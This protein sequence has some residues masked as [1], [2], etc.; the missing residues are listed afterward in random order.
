MLNRRPA[1][2]FRQ[3]C[4]IAKEQLPAP[5]P[6]DPFNSADWKEAIRLRVTSLGFTSP[7]SD[8][9]TKAMNATEHVHRTKSGNGSAHLSRSSP[10]PRAPKTARAVGAWHS[11]TDGGHDY[12]QRIDLD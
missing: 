3:L 5:T 2:G 6:D 4:L 7:P 1:I 11:T 12:D 8:L 10:P 9:L